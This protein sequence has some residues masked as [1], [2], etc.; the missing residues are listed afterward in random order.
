MTGNEKSYP[1]ESSANASIPDGET[2]LGDSRLTL[3]HVKS[4]ALKISEGQI[5]PKEGAGAI[6]QE[7]NGLLRLVEQR[8]Q[9]FYQ[10]AL[11]GDS[12]PS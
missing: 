1:A 8:E 2:W 9:A 7:I 6:L 10:W 3:E 4:L 5:D 12:L 11:E